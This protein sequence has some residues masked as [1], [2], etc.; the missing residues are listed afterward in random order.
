SLARRQP[1]LYPVL[2]TEILLRVRDGVPIFAATKVRCSRWY[3]DAAGQY[4]QR[5]STE[6]YPTFAKHLALGYLLRANSLHYRLKKGGKIWIE[7]KTSLPENAR[8]EAWPG[9]WD[10]APEQA[11]RLLLGAQAGLV[12]DFA[13]GLLQRQADFCRGLSLEPWLA[14]VVRPFENTAAFAFAALEDRLDAPGVMAALLQSPL[15]GIR[16]RGLQALGGS[17][18]KARLAKDLE[19]AALLLCSPYP[20]LRDFL[21][22]RIAEMAD[23]AAE[24]C[25]RAVDRLMLLV[26]KGQ[27]L[28]S[29]L[30]GVRDF[31][32][33]PL[34]GKTSR[35]ALELLL[36]HAD[37]R[38]QRLGAHL[39]SV[40]DFAY[41]ELVHLLPLLESAD[42]PEL[43]AAALRLLARLPAEQQAEQA[44]TLL[45]TLLNGEDALRAAARELLL[46]LKQP[47]HQR[48]LFAAMVPWL[49]R[50]QAEGPGEDL[51]ALVA[52]FDKIYA[53]IDKNLLWRL[54]T[55]RSK[56]AQQAGSLIV[57]SRTAAE[58][59]LH[60]LVILS[61]HASL[62]VRSWALNALQNDPRVADAKPG[63]F[64]S[65]LEVLDNP[66][67]DTRAAAIAWLRGLPPGVWTP[68]RTIAV[69]DQV[70]DDVQRFGRDLVS[71]HFDA[72]H[73][74]DYLLRLSQH[75]SRQVQL[76]VSG[77]LATYASGNPG[78]L[79]RLRP[80]FTTV[81]AQVNRGRVVKERVLSLLRKEAE[82]SEPV[83]A[84]LAELLAEQS[85][86]A[87]VA[88]K[89]RYLEALFAL[90]QQDPALP[91]PLRVISPRK[92]VK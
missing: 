12:N 75:P 56:L 37:G 42:D 16:A 35:Q 52:G 29:V 24:L 53:G 61:R 28:E 46:G 1:E 67:E 43:R 82:T 14:L 77:F 33:G 36:A 39:L 76:F 55:A 68:E 71:S 65:L 6:S 87:V 18:G 70:Y 69:C 58:F 31:L 49:F 38:L 48:A 72:G 63:G 41:A 34:R 2:A 44:Q 4:Q 11:L 17:V 10:K 62:G 89:A 21:Q 88:D 27:D 83:A 64:E 57:V 23:I 9:L 45:S 84:M 30:P 8:P 59:S 50:S 22:A 54:L 15:A 7:V 66:W 80:Y 79:L 32:S 26:A 5:S 25:N 3:T 13:L 81:L 90:Q 60:Q 92:A 51:I 91:S 85:L 47:A 73:G 20:E 78:L 86:T 19:L 40:S 74:E